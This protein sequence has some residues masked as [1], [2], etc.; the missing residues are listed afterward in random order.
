VLDKGRQR[1]TWDLQT[2]R[3]ILSVGMSEASRT[4]AGSIVRGASRQDWVRLQGL[5]GARFGDECCSWNRWGIRLRQL[6][7]LPLPAF[8]PSGNPSLSLT[9]PSL[10][11]F[12]PSLSL[13][14]PSLSLTYRSLF[15]GVV[16]TDGEYAA[17][18]HDL[19]L[20]AFLP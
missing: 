4:G 5:R 17:H 7:D 16:E 13:T 18:V 11:L 3:L 19:P 20:P 15:S 8:L 9:Y 1:L 12:F 6:Q 2:Q 14:Y 10:S